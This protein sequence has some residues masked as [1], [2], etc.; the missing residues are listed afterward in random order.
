MTEPARPRLLILSFSPIESDARVL[1]QVRHFEKH[2]DVTT[3]GYGGAPSGGVTH[4]RIPDDVP[5]RQHTREMLVLRRYRRIYW[6][7]P[8]LRFVQG[9]LGAERF[10]IVLAND[11]ETVGLAL[12]L[13]PALGVHADI[14]EYAPRLYEEVPV[15]RYFV[16][17]FVRW[18]CRRFLTK[19]TSVTTV[20]EGI[21]REYKRVFGIDCGVV[22]NAAPAVD[23]RPTP[24]QS[25]IRIV[26][27]GAALRNRG[28]ERVV[29]AVER[30]STDLTLDLYLMPN[31][32]GFLDELTRHAET[33]SRV[34]LN[35]P[36]PYARLA[37]TL[38][39]YDLGIHVIPPVNFNNT[40][41][42]PNK[43]FD[44]V[45][46]RLGLIIGPS[47]EMAAILDANG[48]GAVAAGFETADIVAVMDALDATTVASWKANSDSAASALSAETQVAV[49]DRAI[50]AIAALDAG[51]E[52]AR[53]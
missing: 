23:V 32:V 6:H 27:S 18:Q 4:V 1:K 9:A 31:D 17:P 46:A 8:A 41:A 49:W 33:S 43:F 12:S 48:I 51:P 38:N 40:L 34:T 13:E 20:G 22:T 44:Y 47:P 25:P 39:D 29:E 30:S 50:A 19:A 10:D 21:A 45:Q 52:A 15:W 7:S 11:I 24:V 53:P 2:Y 28:I 16:A 3:C 35:P 36:V 26:H 5:F 37:A 14:H 42:L